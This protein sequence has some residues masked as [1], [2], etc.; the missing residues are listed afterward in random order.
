MRRQLGCTLLLAG[1]GMAATMPAGASPYTDAVAADAPVAWWRFEETSGTSAPSSAGS[2][3]GTYAGVAL[4]QASVHPNLGLAGGFDGSASTVDVPALGGFASLTLEAWVRPAALPDSWSALYNTDGF[5][6][7]ASHWQFYAPD[8]GAASL[9]WALGFG[10][11]GNNVVFT[12]D[13]W[14]HIVTTYDAVGGAGLLYVN[15][16]LVQTLFNLPGLSPILSDGQLGSWNG[17]SRFLNG[18]L[19]EVAVYGVVLSADRVQAHYAAATADDPTATPEPASAALLLAGFL[20]LAG[21]RRRKSA[22]TP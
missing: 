14:Y 16:A 5:G 20:G 9:E 4:G 19:D 11:L 8:E 21:C 10:D 22:A 2:F 13:N 1:L 18:L 7:S 3:V 15:G 6:P 17:T 12:P